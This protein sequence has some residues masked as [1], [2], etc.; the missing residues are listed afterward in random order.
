MGL[1]LS[2][3]RRASHGLSEDNYLTYTELPPVS[4]VVNAYNDADHI[5]ALLNYILHQD[6]PEFEVIVVDNGS[7]DAT[8]D[9]VSEMMIH[10]PNLRFT[11][12]PE[13]TRGLSR[14]KLSLMVGIKA[15]RYD[16]IIVTNANSR[17]TT[18]G[19]LRA[20]M[21]NF[22]PG[23]DLVL[24]YAHIRYAG[25]HGPMRSYREFNAV[26]ADSIWLHAATTGNL[27]RGTADNLAFSKKL[28][29]DHNGYADSMHL[30]WGEDD[31]WVQ[32]VASG[33]NYRLE[34]TP[35]AEVETDFR[36]VAYAWRILKLR[37]DFTTGILPHRRGWR[38]Q[39]LLSTLHYLVP[40]LGLGAILWNTY[41]TSQ[42]SIPLLATVLVTMLIHG[43]ATCLII[44]RLCSLLFAPKLFFSTMLWTYVRPLMN[45]RYRIIGL[46][47]RKS[48][49]TSMYD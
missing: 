9:V 44:N 26:T 37:R 15:A 8:K 32:H 11:F 22:V 45:L 28:F 30:K 29:Y 10:F 3:I 49:Y 13:H 21:R 31:V 34:I 41:L 47:T 19:W 40:I 6:Y 36:N 16:H 39:G 7:D 5:S 38:V 14:R 18:E 1:R 33:S 25:D 4:V 48:N 27:L 17:P 43:I 24:G 42:L 23:I 2:S 35:Q 46:R 12:I 20:M